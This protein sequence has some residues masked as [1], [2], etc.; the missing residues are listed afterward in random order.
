MD[1]SGSNVY[2][3]ILHGDTRGCVFDAE[4]GKVDE[5]GR[6]KIHRGDSVEIRL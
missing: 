2:V 5:E 6:G 3:C 4:W 1:V